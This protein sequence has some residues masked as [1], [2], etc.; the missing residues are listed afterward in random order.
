MITGVGCVFCQRVRQ[1]GEW[2]MQPEND[3]SVVRRFQLVQP[4]GNRLA[5]RIAHHPALQRGDAVARQHLLAIMERQPVSQAHRPAQPVD[6]RPR[7]ELLVAAIQ[8][9][10][11]HRGI[12]AGDQRGGPDRIEACKVR[13]RHMD[14]RLRLGTNGGLGERS[15]AKRGGRRSRK[16]VTA[17]H[18]GRSSKVPAV[19]RANVPAD[20]PWGGQSSAD[21][22]HRFSL[23][24]SP[25]PA[26]E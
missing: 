1:R 9:F 19:N 4:G 6:L 24:P 10:E 20:H 21:T 17:L 13:L 16:E 23:R 11:H 3:G 14:Q 5:D 12:V 22:H 8:G 7:I 26:T 2:L 18:S 25:E 15:A